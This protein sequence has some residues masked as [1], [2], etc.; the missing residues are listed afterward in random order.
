MVPQLCKNSWLVDV[1]VGSEG[2]KLLIWSQLQHGMQQGM[3]RAACRNLCP[4]ELCA[5]SHVLLLPGSARRE[6]LSMCPERGVLL[7]CMRM[8]NLR[9]GSGAAPWR[10]GQEEGSEDNAELC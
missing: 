7:C 9:D 4:A 5:C 1:G 8:A 3:A 2:E 10:T 6:M